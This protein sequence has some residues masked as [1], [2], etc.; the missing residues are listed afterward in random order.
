MGQNT[1]AIL[2]IVIL[3]AALI[4][5]NLNNFKSK[6]EE[7]IEEPEKL[8][9]E[10]PY[11]R[12]MLLTKTEYTFYKILKTQCDAANL[13]IC[14]KVRLEDLI[15]VKD[16]NNKSKW[17]GYIKSRHVD[18]IITDAKLNIKAAIELDDK[19][20]NSSRA[21]NTDNFKNNLFK[22]IAIPL[23]RIKTGQ[24]YN[25]AITHIIKEIIDN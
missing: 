10:L 3:V 6:K 2:F 4:I 22:T 21:Q 20:H 16:N 8:Q 1:L 18:F 15:E 14:P 25:E 9:D 7:K 24:E 17:R 12:K 13:L 5:T 11:V 19:S 23:F